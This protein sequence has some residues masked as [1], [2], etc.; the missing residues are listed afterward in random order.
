[1]IAGILLSYNRIHSY[2]SSSNA[3]IKTA[4]EKLAWRKVAREGK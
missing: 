3:A 1:M 2:E 4:A